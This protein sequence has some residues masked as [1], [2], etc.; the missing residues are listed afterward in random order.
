MPLPDQGTI[1]FEC[2]LSG[3]GKVMRSSHFAEGKLCWLCDCKVQDPQHLTP[4]EGVLTQSRCYAFLRS[5]PACR[6]VGD[7]AHCACCLVNTVFKRLL[8]NTSFWG[9]GAIAV[10][11][12]IRAVKQQVA[13]DA[14]GVP[15]EARESAPS[16]PAQLDIS[17]SHLFLST[18][19][20][21]Q[22]LEEAVAQHYPTIF[23]PFQGQRVHA[24]T[25][26]R[27]FLRNMRT[28]HSLWRLPS[29]FSD[30]E[31]EQCQQSIRN[32]VDCWQ[33]FDWKPTVWAHWTAAHSGY[34]AQRYRTLYLFSS[35]ALREEAP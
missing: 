1:G 30:A 22:A 9:E 23:L 18:P 24:H 3:D 28:L 27:I 31:V 16:T 26:L 13:W 7:V 35:I 2:F 5:I 25:V 6:R 19:S 12:C 11:R 21:H 34:F 33:A 17:A 14:D 8:T 32:F 20:F 15:T 4:Q 10:S 29:L